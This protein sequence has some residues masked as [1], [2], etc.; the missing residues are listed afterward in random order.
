MGDAIAIISKPVFEKLAGGEPKLGAEYWIERYDSTHKGLDT[1]ADGG[2]LY[3]VTVR[4]GDVLWLVQS[5][6]VLTKDDKGWKPVSNHCATVDLTPVKHLLDITRYVEPGKL[7]MSLQTP[8]AL[9]PHDARLLVHAANEAHT[10]Y[11]RKKVF[12]VTFPKWL[13]EDA[14]KAGAPPAPPKPAKPAKPAPPKPAK[15]KPQAMSLSEILVE[16]ALAQI[17]EVAGTA[18]PAKLLAEPKRKKGLRGNFTETV[19]SVFGGSELG[20]A[21]RLLSKELAPFVDG[22]ALGLAL[23]EVGDDVPSDL[24][25][26]FAIKAIDDLARALVALA[27]D[28][29]GDVPATCIGFRD[30]L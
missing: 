7:A 5:L 15:K 22:P 19:Q 6:R 12:N 27:L 1:L 11:T 30:E 24:V 25:D 26:Q 8:R 16:G 20:E 13:L 10:K 14:A 29:P 21:R 9:T 23:A 4:P 3:L 17:E 28:R 2:A 18:K